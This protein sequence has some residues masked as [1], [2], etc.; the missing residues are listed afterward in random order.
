MTRVVDVADPTYPKTLNS[1]ASLPM[2]GLVSRG[3]FVMTL[4]GR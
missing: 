3:L 2:E 4:P 1:N